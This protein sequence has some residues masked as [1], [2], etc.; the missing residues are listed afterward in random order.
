VTRFLKRSALAALAAGVLLLASAGSA[1]AAACWKALLTDWYD[2][3][4]DKVYAIP[5]YNQA[6]Q[7]LPEDVANYSSARD[8][9]MR[10]LQSAI[11]AQNQSTTTKPATTKTTKTTET[12]DT[13]ETTGVPPSTTPPTD[14]TPPPA[15]TT[16]ATTTPGRAQP[17]GIEGAIDKLNP[18][19][20]DSFPLPLL[21]LGGL[22][23]LLVAAG[24]AGMIWRRYQGGGAGTL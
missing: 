17:K 8:D 3:K 19:D 7:H 12:T 14:T 6:V 4:I 20:A 24:L 9:I 2:G 1:S 21:I 15:D 16:P 13:T 18:G 23:I 22:A 5:C 10:A 11:A